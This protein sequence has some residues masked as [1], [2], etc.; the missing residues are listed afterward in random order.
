M[1]DKLKAVVRRRKSPGSAHPPQPATALPEAS[2]CTLSGYSAQR[3]AVPGAPGVAPERA[4]P[5]GEI[6]LSVTAPSTRPG[7]GS[8][9]AAM[10]SALLSRKRRTPTAEQ[11]AVDSALLSRLKRRTP[12]AE[13]PGDPHRGRRSQSDVKGQSSYATCS[14]DPAALASSSA[15]LASAASVPWQTS[16]STSPS[17]ISSAPGLQPSLVAS[18]T[19]LPLPLNVDWGNFFNLLLSRSRYPFTGPSQPGSTPQASLAQP[20]PVTLANSTVTSDAPASTIPGALPCTAGRPFMDFLPS[21]VDPNT[22]LPFVISRT[23]DSVSSQPALPVPSQPVDSGPFADSGSSAASCSSEQD[24]DGVS[25]PGVDPVFLR[26]RPIVFLAERYPQFFVPATQTPQPLAEVDVLLG[27]AQEP[28]TAF[29][30]E[31]SALS[32]ALLK[33][34]DPAFEANRPSK[35]FPL[36]RSFPLGSGLLPS[37]PLPRVADDPSLRHAPVPLTDSGSFALTASDA[38]GGEVTSHEA[39]VSACTASSLLTILTQLLGSHN[40]DSAGVPHFQIHESLD[41]QAI[42]ACLHGLSRTMEH[43]IAASA[44]I[45]RRFIV[46]RRSIALSQSRLPNSVRADLI[47]SPFSKT[48]LFGPSLSASCQLQADRNRDLFISSALTGDRGGRKRSTAPRPAHS[49]SAKRRF[50]SGF[51][52]PSTSAPQPSF[53]PRPQFSEQGAR[54]RPFRGRAHGDSSR[55]GSSRPS[56]GALRRPRRGSSF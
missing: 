45:Y 44:A 6:G 38:R 23:S 36:H 35:A 48:S 4:R 17:A 29:L 5:G 28:T 40:P 39:L 56:R 47:S 46:A 43:S 54:P 51:P 10:D 13:R 3:L 26:S 16:M 52:Q 18:G 37:G 19:Q 20:P 12:T 27:M 11:G 53:P 1:S 9:D 55:A 41:S 22:G 50:R 21:S 2:S 14:S 33:V 30:K 49:Q 34:F 32:A 31:P 7:P 8:Q 24:S 15:G 25:L 42:T